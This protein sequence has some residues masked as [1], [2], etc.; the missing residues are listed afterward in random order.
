MVALLVEGI[1]EMNTKID[2]LGNVLASLEQSNLTMQNNY[3][4]LF[5]QVQTLQQ[6]LNNCCP[7]T[8]QQSVPQNSAHSDITNSFSENNINAQPNPFSKFTELKIQLAEKSKNKPVQIVITDL[9]GKII[10]RLDMPK[11]KYSIEIAGN[12]LTEG[13]Y[14]CTLLVDQKIAKTI[15]ILHN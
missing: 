5:N 12:E 6:Q 9:T 7:P 1:K 11:F 2:S 3:Q 8:F 10:K 14:Y 13:M 4:D 15:Q